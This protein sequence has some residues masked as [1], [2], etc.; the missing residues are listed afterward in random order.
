MIW[1]EDV[2]A[3]GYALQAWPLP[4]LL[5]IC[6][7]SGS[8]RLSMFDNALGLPAEASL[9]WNNATT[10]DFFRVQQHKVEAFCSGL[11]ARRLHARLGARTHNFL[12]SHTAHIAQRWRRFAA[13]CTRVW[14]QPL[15]CRSS[16]TR[17]S[18]RTA[19]YV[20]TRS[21]TDETNTMNHEPI[22]IQHEF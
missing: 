16:M 5:D 2:V 21:N 6:S 19:F 4:L 17:C 8:I 7:D 10:L 9:A 18:L 14:G 20:R 15:A 3:I 11:H 13:G 12:K 1:A 22:L